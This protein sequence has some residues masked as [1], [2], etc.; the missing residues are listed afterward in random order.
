[1]MRFE[2]NPPRRFFRQRFELP[3]NRKQG[4]HKGEY[5]GPVRTGRGHAEAR[6]FGDVRPNSAYAQTTAMAKALRT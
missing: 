2:F 3:P 4:A 6:L 5:I 1:M